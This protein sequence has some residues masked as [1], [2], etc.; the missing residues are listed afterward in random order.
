M[1][2]AL[3]KFIIL[4]V[5]LAVLKG[6]STYN[7]TF[8]TYTRYSPYYS[9]GYILGG[10][11]IQITLNTPETGGLHALP[12][13]SITFVLEPESSS[14]TAPTCT[15]VCSSTT[16]C[17]Y[18]CIIIDSQR[19]RLNS[20]KTNTP[21]DANGGSSS[22]L[23]YYTITAVSY[24]TSA[25]APTTTSPVLL[26]GVETFRDRITRLIYIDSTKDL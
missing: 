25:G 14:V 7:P 19:Y 23:Q 24:L 20:T 1:S 13:N 15:S 21:S 16:T 2:R 9:L 6:Q 10:N 12:M 8:N 11:S 3:G 17:V 4:A 5:L 26:K 18:N 22:V